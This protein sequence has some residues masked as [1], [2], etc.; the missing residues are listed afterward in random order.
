LYNHVVKHLRLSSLEKKQHSKSPDDQHQPPEQDCLQ[1]LELRRAA[2]S[3]LNGFFELFLPKKLQG[4]AHSLR[5]RI[6]Q[7]AQ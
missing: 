5:R 7:G 3:P 6:Q 4:W 2:F 1:K